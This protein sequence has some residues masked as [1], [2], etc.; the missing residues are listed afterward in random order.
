MSSS[1]TEDDRWRAG[2]SAKTSKRSARRARRREV[3]RR[4]PAK[5]EGAGATSSTGRPGA[6]FPH[7]PTDAAH[8]GQPEDATDQD[9]SPIPLQL[10]HRGNSATLQFSRWMISRQRLSKCSLRV[11]GKPRLPQMLKLGGDRVEGRREVVTHGGHNADRCN[12]NEGCDQAV[13]DGRC[14]SLIFQ[15]SGQGHAHLRAP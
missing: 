11:E 12:G 8:V 13:F 4:H 7:P 14:A 3:D 9:R 15:K 5:Y 6:P 10:V 2:T 1:T